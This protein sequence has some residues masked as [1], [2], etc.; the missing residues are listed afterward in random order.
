MILDV[1]YR[2]KMTIRPTMTILQG[3]TARREFHPKTRNILTND[4]VTMKERRKSIRASR[5]FSLNLSEI[6]GDCNYEAD[7]AKE[8]RSL[9][10]I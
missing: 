4:F 2:E 7:I 5:I 6:M 8:I 1:L 9:K 3:T 10:V